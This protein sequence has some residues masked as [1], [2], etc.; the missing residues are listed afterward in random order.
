MPRTSR[1]PSLAVCTTS[2]WW[3]PACLQARHHLAHAGRL[4]DV[5]VEGLQPVGGGHHVGHED[6]AVADAQLLRDGDGLLAQHVVGRQD[7]RHGLLL[8]DHQQHAHAALDHEGMR[9][10]HR[11]LRRGHRGRD[12]LEV[13]HHEEG[14]RIQRH[15]RLAPAR[16]GTGELRRFAAGRARCWGSWNASWRDETGYAGGRGSANRSTMGTGPLTGA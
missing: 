9:L 14:G 6:V 10:F 12:A 5:H 2:A 8:A 16:G 15:A 1:M 4:H 7:A 13:G 3:R 11:V